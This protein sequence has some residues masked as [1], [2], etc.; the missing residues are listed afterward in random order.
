MS[1]SLAKLGKFTFISFKNIF[2]ISCP[3]PS[4][5][6]IPMIRMLTEMDE[7][8][9]EREEKGKAMQSETYRESTVKGRK[10]GLKSMIWTR[11]KK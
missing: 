8:G 3:S 2:P 5:F 1:I 11:W 4:P 9:C 7:Y 10:L 6:G